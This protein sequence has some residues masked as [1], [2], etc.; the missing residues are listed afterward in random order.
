MT[1]P[2]GRIRC[3]CGAVAHIL[4]D[5][6]WSCIDHIRKASD[7]GSVEM[8]LAVGLAAVVPVVLVVVFLS[9]LLGALSGVQS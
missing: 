3:Q 6:E 8:W 9:M 2:N 1:G 7:R 5:N 4:W